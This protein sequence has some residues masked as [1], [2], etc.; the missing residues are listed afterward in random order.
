MMKINEFGCPFCNKFNG[1]VDLSYFNRYFAQ[2]YNI[3][4]RC[5]YETKNFA[6]VPS[7]G[8]FVEGYLLIVPR[9]HFLSFREV[10][11]QHYDELNSIIN[12]I[13]EFYNYCYHSSFVIFEH[14]SSFDGKTGGMSVT[15]A[16]LHIL[17]YK[18]SLISIISDFDFIRFENFN[19]FNENI[20]IRQCEKPYLFFKDIDGMYYYSENANI[21][22][23]FFRK[24]ICNDLGL[25]G[26]GDWK[27]YPFVDNIKETIATF[28]KYLLNKNK[29]GNEN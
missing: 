8:S 19:A 20:L 11:Y 3:E 1:K 17:P 10:P 21:P 4:Q 25:Q 7:L 22:S 23:Q 12:V 9:Q 6:C 27:E 2:K 5:V 16:H 13:A 15:H 29:L 18:Q 26:K 14:G 28:N 24:I